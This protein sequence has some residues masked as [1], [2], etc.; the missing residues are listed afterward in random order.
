MASIKEPCVVIVGPTATGK[1][2]LGVTL[3]KTLQGEV[4]NGDAMQVYRDLDIGT[5]KVTEAEADGVAH[6]L[7]DFLEPTEDYS[8]ASFQKDARKWIHDLNDR[9]VLPILVGGTGL[10]V[11]AVLYD[12]QFNDVSEDPTL[13][14]ELEQR[15]RLEGADV[16]YRELLKVDPGAEKRIH[17][18]NVQ[19]VVRALEIYHKT[20]KPM[21]EALPEEQPSLLYDPIVIG[22]TM[23]RTL[24]YERINR[25]VDLMV[26][27]GLVQEAES[28]YNRG[29]RKTQAVMAIGYKE[30]FGAFDGAYSIGEAVELIKRNSRR[31][32]K[33]QLTWFRHQMSMDWFDLTEAVADQ[34][35]MDK[36]VDEIVQFV[37]GKLKDRSNYL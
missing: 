1:T 36:K 23:D 35:V 26:D 31:F 29:I 13:R 19:R 17:P 30:L 11:K 33:R 20:G 6:H 32:A 24:L 16:L 14:T 2:K 21:S 10:Y 22:L 5:A 25:R 8:V 4:I 12:Y 34:D 28:L 9:E 7:L 3:A 15:A 18:N 37:A 27:Q